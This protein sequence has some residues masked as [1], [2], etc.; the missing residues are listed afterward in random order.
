MAARARV[1]SDEL[2]EPRR[3]L[4]ERRLRPTPSRLEVLAILRRCATPLTHGEVMISLRARGVCVDPAT[5]YRHLMA[6]CAAG[7]VARMDLGDHAWRFELRSADD[8]T[9]LRA[10]VVCRTCGAIDSM[11]TD[12]VLIA[13]DLALPG[14]LRRR[15]AGISIEAVCDHCHQGAG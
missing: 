9:R 1:E 5:T 12:A 4:T 3:W 6:F 15:E 7:L 8:G 14:A 2:A 11:P 10:H 13:A